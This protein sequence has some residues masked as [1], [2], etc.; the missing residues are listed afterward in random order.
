MEG[1]KNSET[2]ST[3]LF[4]LP[5]FTAFFLGMS[6]I[7]D[8]VGHF[9]QSYKERYSLSFFSRSKSRERKYEKRE[10]DNTSAEGRRFFLKAEKHHALKLGRQ[11]IR[12]LVVKRKGNYRCEA[13]LKQTKKKIREDFLCSHLGDSVLLASE[14]G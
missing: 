2:K 8:H 7:Q 4:W 13:Q 12:L 9:V 6:L 5:E 10:T 1:E 14:S 11:D 3:L